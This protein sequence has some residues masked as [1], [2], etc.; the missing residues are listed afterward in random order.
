MSERVVII[1]NAAGGKPTL[2]RALADR[3][4]LKRVEV[5]CLLW[6]PGWKLAPQEQHEREHAEAIAETGWIIEGPG[7]QDSI[8]ARLKRATEIILVDLPLWMHFW[9]AAERQIAWA[10]GPIDHAPA[11]AEAMPPTRDLFRTIW[12]VDQTWMPGIRVLC[13]AAEQEGKRVV[14]IHS[15]DELDAFTIDAS[16]RVAG[17]LDAER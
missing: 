8:P 3:R 1:G 4:G 12:E 10:K 2:A 5:D 13:D 16:S 11:G 9:L 14:R 15:I 17:T 7:R 6:L